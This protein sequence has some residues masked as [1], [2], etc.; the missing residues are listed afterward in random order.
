LQVSC[1]LTDIDDFSSLSSKDLESLQLNAQVIHYLFSTLSKEM[2]EVII[3]EED[4]REDA[5]LIWELL[6]EM[7]TEPQSDDR[8]REAEMSPEE[9]SS[10]SPTC[11]EPQVTLMKKQND[12]SNT[13]LA[14]LQTL[15]RPVGQIS[16]TDSSRGAEDLCSEGTNQQESSKVTTSPTPSCPRRE[17]KNQLMGLNELLT[18]ELDELKKSHDLLLNRYEAL[19]NDYVWALKL[20]SHLVPVESSYVVLKCKFEKITSEHMALQTNHKELES[21]HEKLVESYAALH[22]AHEVVMASVKLYQPPTHTCTCSHVENMLFCDKSCCSQ[23]TQFL[24]EHVVVECCDDLITQENDEL[25]REVEKLKLE[26]TKL[27]RKGQVQPSQDNCDIMVKKLEKG[28]NVTT[29]ALQ[30]GQVK[31]RKNKTMLARR[32]RYLAKTRACFRCKEKGHMIAAC[33]MTQSEADSDQIGQTG[34]CLE[35]T[36]SLLHEQAKVKINDEACC[37]ASAR[38]KDQ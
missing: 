14:F 30:Q 20:S 36:T 31:K 18:E 22:V 33:L 19:A 13:V 28:T 27:K 29:S 6:E 12:Q 8:A 38:C 32:Q 24:V 4:I 15:V 21:S 37:Q 5:H 1:H 23:A 34:W 10:S 7:Y 35:S 2:Q 16:Q 11:S 25:K 9:C 26:L 17:K 3:E